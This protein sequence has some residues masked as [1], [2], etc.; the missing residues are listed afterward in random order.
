MSFPARARRSRARW[1]FGPGG[2][3]GD[4]FFGFSGAK[5][6]VGAGGGLW[7][8]SKRPADRPIGGLKEALTVLAVL[9]RARGGRR[10]QRARNRT[11]LHRPVGGAAAA[12]RRRHFFLAD[13]CSQIWGGRWK[14]GIG[15][16]ADGGFAW[17]GG[18]DS[19][20]AGERREA[21]GGLNFVS[22]HP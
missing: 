2:G 14:P 3:A 13:R 1:E 16:D 17:S 22:T 6:L 11:D 21:A 19:A 20:G 4:F 18:G 10:F 7:G 15:A 5:P 8:S 12:G 9:S